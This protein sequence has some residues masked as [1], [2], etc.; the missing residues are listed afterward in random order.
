[1]TIIKVPDEL[2]HEIDRMAGPKRRSAYAI[3][4]LWLD[5]QRH[6]QMEALE[7]SSGAWKLEDHPELADGA[8]AYVDKIRS[9]PDE[10]FED[11][12]RRHEN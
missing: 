4:V 12:L 5:I 10:R 2:A 6:R 7:A 11:A 3:E 9:E 1:M 8:A